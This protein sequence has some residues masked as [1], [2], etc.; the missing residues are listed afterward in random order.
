[1]NH[2]AFQDVK[3]RVN[4]TFMQFLRFHLWNLFLTIFTL[5]LASP[6]VAYRHLKFIQK[7]Y[8]LEGDAESLKTHQNTDETTGQDGASS[9]LDISD[10]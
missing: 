5:G 1:M 9:L 3:L 6:Y 7:Y 8:S 10:F 2:Q 4:Y